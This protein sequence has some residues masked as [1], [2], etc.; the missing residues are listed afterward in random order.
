MA[1]RRVNVFSLAFLDAMTCGLG[2]VILLYMVINAGVGLR[3]DQLAD[4]LEE[5]DNASSASNR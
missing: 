1:R 2:A 3:T 5:P 4:D